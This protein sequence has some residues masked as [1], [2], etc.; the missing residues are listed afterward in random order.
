M[1]CAGAIVL[2][3]NDPVGAWGAQ[4]VMR[5]V[6]GLAIDVRAVGCV[7]MCHAEPLVEVSVEGAPRTMYAEVGVDAAA[8]ILEEHVAHGRTLPGLEIP[9]VPHLGYFDL[10]GYDPSASRQLRIVLRNCGIIDPT[11]IDEYIARGGYLG[12][13]RALL[14]FS[15]QDIVD[16]VTRSGLR[17]RG[18]AGYPTGKKWAITRATQAAEKYIICNGDEGDPGAYM[19]RSVLEG[20]PHAILEGLLIGAYAIG[21]SSGYLYIRAEYP[22][23]VERIE[24]AIQRARRLGLVGKNILGT[25]FSCDLEVRLGAGAFVCGEETALIASVEGRRGTPRPRPPYP[26]E[27]GLWGMPSCITT[28]NAEIRSE[29]T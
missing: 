4:R 1:G 27:H 25:D 20:D 22:L 26:S 14:E 6:F 18:G 5:E 16:Q 21:A 28:S 8:R 24:K 19:D 29:A 9:G 17:G 3:A 12:L 11:S 15:P 13:R 2:C 7:G 23:A 10:P